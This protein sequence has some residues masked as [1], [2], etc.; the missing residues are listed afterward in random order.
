MILRLVGIIR[1]VDTRVGDMG[2]LSDNVLLCRELL[3]MAQPASEI[4]PNLVIPVLPIQEE[5]AT[6]AQIS[7]Q[8]VTE[9]MI[10][11][12]SEK[13]IARRPEAPRSIVIKNMDRLKAPAHVYKN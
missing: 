7:V 12:R 2:V 4:S 13:I 9:T 5:L 11:L 3:R 10:W 6:Q 8:M 1:Q